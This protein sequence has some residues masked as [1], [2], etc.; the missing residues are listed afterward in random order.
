MKRKLLIDDW[1]R[2]LLYSHSIR[3]GA[4]GLIGLAA[5]ELLYLW[6]GYDLAAPQFWFWVSF[7]LLAYGIFGRIKYQ[8]L[9]Q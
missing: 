6:M 1:R 7:V 5:P 4:L 2:V 8:G 3:A 9:D